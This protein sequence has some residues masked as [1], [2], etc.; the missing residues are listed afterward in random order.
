MGGLRGP[1]C[2]ILTRPGP[3]IQ[4]AHEFVMKHK[5]LSPTNHI[6]LGR[7]SNF[8]LKETQKVIAFQSI[9]DVTCKGV[10][11]LEIVYW[12]PFLVSQEN[13]KNVCWGEGEER[14][15]SPNS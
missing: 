8:Q 9:H 5:L 12:N 4:K 13:E 15:D 7:K 6:P 10:T 14:R 1:T 2:V 11:T 3:E